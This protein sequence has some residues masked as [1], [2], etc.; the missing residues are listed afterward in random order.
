MRLTTALI[1]L[2]AALLT[3]ACGDKDDGGGTDGTSAA[4]GTSSAD[5]TSS[6]GADGTSSAD[7]DAD[8]V[9]AEDGD[10]DDDD[11]SVYPGAADPTVDGTDQDCD[12]V[13]GPDA[14][15]DGHADA[16]AGGDDCDDDDASISPSA[17]EIWGDDV[18]QDCDGQPDME[19]AACSADLTV[20]ATGEAATTQD[21]CQRW[22]LS[23]TLDYAP[24]GSDDDPPWVIGL[25][26]VLSAEASADLTCRLDLT[27]QAM[28]TGLDGSGSES[29]DYYDVAS[30]TTRVELALDGCSWTSA[31]GTAVALEQGFLRIDTATA[32]TTAGDQEG[33]PVPLDVAARLHAWG[34]G[35][36]VEG[37][38]VVNA[39]LLGP[40][41]TDAV[42]CANLA[43]D[44]DG[45]GLISVDLGG[46]DC[47]DTDSASTVISD[48][49]DCD[50]IVTADDCDDTDPTHPESVDDLDCDGVPEHA[51]GGRMIR[52]AAS[53]FD[54]GCTAAQEAECS[55][56][57]R[58]VMPVTLTRDTFLAEA[59]VTQDEYSAL[60]GDAPSAD[61]TCGGTCPVE[62]VTWSMA[63]AFTNAL[64]AASGFEQCYIC[65]GTGSATSC[66]EAMPIYDCDGYRLPTEAEWEGAARCGTDLVYAG[67]DDADAVG[68]YDGN[69]GD[70]LHPV[71]QLAANGCG[72]Y[73]LSGNV[74]E[75]VHDQGS[76]SYYTEEGRTDPVS[77]GGPWQV[78]RGGGWSGGVAG[79]RVSRRGM[80]PGG[81]NEP[82]LGFRVARTAP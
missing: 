66:S 38:I 47:D 70:R 65:T 76:S 12:G 25:A 56:N 22:S 67:S 37:D 58:P 51:G 9:T 63:A 54:M 50:G 59:E 3:T 80:N 72:L 14:D 57:E 75:W 74:W 6:D 31:S 8:G 68:W 78:A 79:L 33:L 15:G 30:E 16:A 64:S 32:G 53:S 7:A 45:D 55:G 11:S 36:E 82:F 18:D 19:G 60:M 39:R 5:D 42:E 1:V 20:T 40:A 2:S 27:Q 26:L 13:D 4:D 73:D 52:I 17:S 49:A 77:T 24:L 62:S 43:V 34:D 71:Q 10:C 44:R 21:F 46:T 41:D 81:Y 61:A 35:V 69:S 23:P 48:D 29:A 28:C